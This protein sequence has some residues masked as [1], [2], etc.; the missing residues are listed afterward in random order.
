MQ[1]LCTLSWLMGDV[2]IKCQDYYLAHI[3]MCVKIGA[4][5]FSAFYAIVFKYYVSVLKFSI[6]L[7]LFFL[8]FI[9]EPRQKKP[10]YTICEQ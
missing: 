5:V 8:C 3:Y 10:V 1:H 4:F 7:F 9:I 2:F 6:L